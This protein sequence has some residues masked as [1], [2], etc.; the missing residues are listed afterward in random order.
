MVIYKSIRQF[1]NSREWRTVAKTYAKSKNLLCERCLK[2][3]LVVPYEEVHHKTRLTVQNINDPSIA[4]NFNNLECLCRN[5]HE[6][7]HREDAKKRAT[8][9]KNYTGKEL[10]ERKRFIVDQTTGEITLLPEEE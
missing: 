3:G 7:E 6:A 1:Y 2:K 5:C 4:F 9:K 10:P 8:L